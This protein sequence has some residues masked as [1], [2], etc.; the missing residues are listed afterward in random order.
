MA[1]RPRTE[2]QVDA[3]KAYSEA[4]VQISL[5]LTL[6]EAAQVDKQRGKQSRAAWIKAKALGKGK[7]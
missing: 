6:D 2:A 4:R 3:E 7:K 1:K 5:R